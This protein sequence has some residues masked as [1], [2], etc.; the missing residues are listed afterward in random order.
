MGKNTTWGPRQRLEGCSYEVN[1]KAPWPG[2]GARER[3]GRNTAPDTFILDIRPP[4]LREN[5]SI[6]LQDTQFVALCFGR[7]RNRIYHPTGHSTP[8]SQ[9]SCMAWDHVSCQS[10]TVLSHPDCECAFVEEKQSDKTSEDNTE[11]YCTSQRL[12][13][14]DHGRA[15]CDRDLRWNREQW[16]GVRLERN[17]E[18]SSRPRT[19]WAGSE[20]QEWL[21][22]SVHSLSEERETGQRCRV[23]IA[24]GF[25]RH[26]RHCNFHSMG[27]THVHFSERTA[28]I[29][30][31]LRKT[32]LI[33]ARKMNWKVKEDWTL[34]ARILGERIEFS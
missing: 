26:L 33:M 21:Q 12:L 34:A 4:Y 20:E 25:I 13:I 27:G 16:V 24:K 22:C 19:T 31:A 5:I 9:V 7:P 17:G 2:L 32:I 8:I 15:P 11:L 1:A 29:T 10:L 6:F 18:A 23:P 30:Q 28:M 14:E 3:H